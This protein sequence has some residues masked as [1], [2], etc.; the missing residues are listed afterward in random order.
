[1]I[2]SVLN[3]AIQLGDLKDD[4]AA[5]L[6]CQGGSYLAVTGSDSPEDIERTTGAGFSAHLVKPVSLEGL[7][8]RIEHLGHSLL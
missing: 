8:N 5:L 7:V 3:Y 1:M 4:L 2:S 6:E